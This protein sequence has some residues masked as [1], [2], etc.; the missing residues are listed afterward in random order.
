MVNYIA[1]IVASIVSFV[2]GMLWYSPFL[3]GNLLMKASGINKKD[4][5]KSKKKGM[6][7]KLLIAFITTIIMVYVLAYLLDILNYNDA[8]SGGL[9]GFLIWLGFMATIGL[10]RILWEGKT[11]SFYLINTLHELV[12][13]VVI[14][15]I[16]GAWG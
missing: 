11:F 3:F 1:V 5:E 2:I 16:L 13:L 12:S 4:I 6:G 15:A 9:V 7:K 10:G 8:V 14:G